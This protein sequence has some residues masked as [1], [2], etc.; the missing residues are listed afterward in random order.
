MHNYIDQRLTSIFIKGHIY[1]YFSVC[2]PYSPSQ[3]FNSVVAQKAV[4]G[5]L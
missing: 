1:Q 5:N 3:L 4:I 2:G